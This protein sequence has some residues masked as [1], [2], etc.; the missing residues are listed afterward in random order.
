[1]KSKKARVSRSNW[2]PIGSLTKE[3]ERQEQTEDAGGVAPTS[4]R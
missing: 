3:G 4:T 1:M 2:V